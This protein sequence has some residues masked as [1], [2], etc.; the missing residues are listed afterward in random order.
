[1]IAVVVTWFEDW[2]HGTTATILGDFDK[3]IVKLGNLEQKAMRR[4][5]AIDET[6]ARLELA[7]RYHSSEAAKANTVAAK[8]KALVAA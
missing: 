8:L 5:K 7:Q 6:F 4:V 2:W 3:L 1:M